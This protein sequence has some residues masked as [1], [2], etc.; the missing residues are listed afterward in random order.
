MAVLPGQLQQLVDEDIS[1]IDGP[2][3]DQGY[4]AEAKVDNELLTHIEQLQLWCSLRQTGMPDEHIEADLMDLSMQ[5]LA[6]AP[7]VF[8]RRGGGDASDERSESAV[9]S[10]DR[11]HSWPCW[12]SLVCGCR[13]SWLWSMDRPSGLHSW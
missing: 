3:W 1:D 9:H 5:G 7:E 12:R 11:F 2:T 13:S 10:V 6:D 8:V 4:Y